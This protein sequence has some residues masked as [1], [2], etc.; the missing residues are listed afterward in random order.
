VIDLPHLPPPAL[1]SD[2][3]CRVAEHSRFIP[4]VGELG[5]DFAG[6]A[7]SL[8]SVA[9]KHLG[10]EDQDVAELDILAA[11]RGHAFDSPSLVGDLNEIADG[12]DTQRTWPKG[13]LAPSFGSSQAQGGGQAWRLAPCSAR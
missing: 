5:F 10:F 13:P 6:L 9:R 2:P 11:R 4:G 12:E 7:S 3:A 8:S 1:G